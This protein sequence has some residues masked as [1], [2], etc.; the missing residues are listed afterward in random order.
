M[1]FFDETNFSRIRLHILRIFS[2]CHHW[3]VRS[4][5]K[6]IDLKPSHNFEHHPIRCHYQ[7]DRIHRLFLRKEN[8]FLLKIVHQR[9][10]LLSIEQDNDH[11]WRKIHLDN[12]LMPIVFV[13]HYEWIKHNSL[14]LVRKFDEF[15]SSFMI[16]FFLFEYNHEFRRKKRHWRTENTRTRTEKKIMKQRSKIKENIHRTDNL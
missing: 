9:K 10:H 4:Y 1:F 12:W 14:L 3:V 16:E 13:I 5:P 15:K 11:R 6:K 7:L 8:I 2:P